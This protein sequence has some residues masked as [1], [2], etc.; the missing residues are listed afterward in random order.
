MQRRAVWIDSTLALMRFDRFEQ[1]GSNALEPFLI[2]DFASRLIGHVEHVDHLVQ[3]CADLG[4][5][6][7]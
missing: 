5:R 4:Q 7:R 3:I 2:Y 1:L 6:D